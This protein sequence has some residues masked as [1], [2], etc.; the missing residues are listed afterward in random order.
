MKIQQ[1]CKWIGISAIFMLTATLSFAQ[2]NWDKLPYQDGEEIVYIVYYNWG[3]VWVP[4]GEVKFVVTEKED[5]L[6]YDVIG[7]S[8]SSYD[9]MFMVRDYYTSQVD[10]ETLN[11]RNFKRDIHEG[12]YI[13]FDSISFDHD[14]HRLTEYFGKTRAKAMRFDFEVD[15]VVQD[16]VSVIYKLRS[17]NITNLDNNSKIPLSIF[18]DKERFDLDVNYLGMETKKI[19]SLGKVRAHHLQ[20]E[21]IDGYVFSEG[22]LMDIWVS[23]DENH[24]P[25]LIESPITIGSVKAI[26]QSAKGLKS[27]APYLYESCNHD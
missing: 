5:C 15:K 14:N 26:L 19:K 11:P 13:R 7:K 1:A 16:M 9:S 22:D 17:S 24:V 6:Q 18:F 23:A 3:F 27:E 21:L 8:F 25:L 2:V 20:P 10:K 4:A 12:N